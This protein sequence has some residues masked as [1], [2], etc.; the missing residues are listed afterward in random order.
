MRDTFMF[1]KIL[2]NSG[3]A[4]EKAEA[5]LYVYFSSSSG[6]NSYDYN[7]KT[8]TEAGFTEEQVAV[9]ERILYPDSEGEL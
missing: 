1:Y 3:L 6:D 5:L 2:V 7:I 4:P 9:F 8:L